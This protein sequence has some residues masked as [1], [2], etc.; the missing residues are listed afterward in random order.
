VT[1]DGAKASTNPCIPVRRPARAAGASGLLALAALSRRMAA[2]RMAAG[3]GAPTKYWLSTLPAD[4]D[5][6]TLVSTAKLR[7]RIE[8]D[9]QELKQE[10]GLDHYEGRGW[11]GFHYHMALCVAAY[12]FLVSE[13]SLIPPSDDQAHP[14]ASPIP[15]LSTTR[16]RRSAPNATSKLQSQPSALSWRATSPDACPVVLVANEPTYDTVRPDLWRL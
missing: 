12:G 9:Y 1:S 3:Q 6:A 10:L 7:W 8:R 13:R 15:G 16:I 14:G 2:R 4:T 11:R 5:I